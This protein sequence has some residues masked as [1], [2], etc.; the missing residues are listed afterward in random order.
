MKIKDIV[1]KLNSC[2]L[3]TDFIIM[4]P[5][6]KDPCMFYVGGKYILGEFD[7]P[8]ILINYDDWDLEHPSDNDE[9][10]IYVDAANK[11]VTGVLEN[12]FY[13]KE[14]DPRNNVIVYEG[15]PVL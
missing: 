14:G 6:T 12:Y 10:D 13:F 9:E 4:G 5:I 2:N 3:E 7:N 15:K 1:E 11:R 8:P